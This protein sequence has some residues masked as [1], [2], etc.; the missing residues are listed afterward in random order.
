MNVTVNGITV[1]G[2]TEDKTLWEFY[3]ENGMSAFNMLKI[4]NPEGTIEY[5][6]T[7]SD[8]PEDVHYISS[9]MFVGDSSIQDIAEWIMAVYP[10]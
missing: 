4:I 2:T 6:Y 10:N 7:W 1:I 8:Y 3:Y 5:E 9:T